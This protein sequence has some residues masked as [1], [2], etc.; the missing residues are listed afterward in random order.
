MSQS[1]TTS[2]T[3]TR[4]FTMDTV[5]LTLRSGG[6]DCSKVGRLSKS[7]RMTAPTCRPIPLIVTLRRLRLRSSINARRRE[8]RGE[9]EALHGVNTERLTGGC[10][11]FSYLAHV[12]EGHILNNTPRSEETSSSQA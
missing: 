12:S 4:D 5:L 7:R 9:H 1:G 6:A 8:T 3:Y 10:S 2:T 11:R